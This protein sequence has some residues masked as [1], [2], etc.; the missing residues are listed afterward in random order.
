VDGTSQWTS[1]TSPRTLT[2]LAQGSHSFRA[3][4]RDAVGNVDPTPAERAWSVDTHPPDTAID[5][6]PSGLE[7]SASAHLGLSSTEAGSTFEC[8]LDAGDWAPCA[9]SWDLAGLGDGPHTARVRARDA[10][11][12]VDPT[13][14]TRDWTVDTA[15]PETSIE[16]GPSGLVATDEATVTLSSSEPGSSFECRLDDAGEWSACDSPTGLTGLGEGRHTIRV[17]ATDVA[18]NT[19]PTP[20]ERTWTVDTSPPDT[21]IDTGPASGRAT[22]AGFALSAGPGATFECRLDGGGWEACASPLE[23]TGLGVGTHV[24]RVRATDPAGNVDPTEAVW[25]WTI[26]AAPVVVPPPSAPESPRPPAQ[27]HGPSLHDLDLALRGHANAT[28]R[29]LRRTGGARLVRGRGL[30][31]RRLDAGVPGRLSLRLRQGG[32]V[33]GSGHSTATGSGRHAVRLRLTRTGLRRLARGKLH[34]ITVEIEFRDSA[35][36]TVRRSAR[37]RLPRWRPLAF[38]SPPARG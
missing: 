8:R 22:R 13:P 18:G 21:R 10:A 38:T 9:S 33:L 2:G 28:A 25:T 14:A 1:C 15:D 17:R 29:L 27:E 19:D 4:A 24:L 3:R 32:A 7:R 26:A 31:V 16:S 35:G 30:T 20:A 12:N 6:G 34:R 37:L 36:R 23:L 11:G 5:S